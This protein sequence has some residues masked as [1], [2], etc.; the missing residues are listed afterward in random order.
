MQES[1][2]LGLPAAKLLDGFEGIMARVDGGE[3]KVARNPVKWILGNREVHGMRLILILIPLLLFAISPAAGGIFGFK[4][5]PNADM[6]CPGGEPMA[7]NLCFEWKILQCQ[8]CRSFTTDIRNRCELPKTMDC[9]DPTCD[10]NWFKWRE[11][12]APILPDWMKPIWHASEQALMLCY[13]SDQ[14]QDEC[15][16]AFYTNMKATCDM[17]GFAMPIMSAGTSLFKKAGKKTTKKIAEEAADETAEEF[18]DKALDAV[19]PD[20]C[21]TGAAA[22]MAIVRERTEHWYNAGQQWL[23]DHSVSSSPV[24]PTPYEPPLSDEEMKYLADVERDRNRNELYKRAEMA[25]SSSYRQIGDKYTLNFKSKNIKWAETLLSELSIKNGQ[26]ILV[27]INTSKDQDCDWY[28][29]A[30][31]ENPFVLSP[32][33]FR[34]GGWGHTWELTAIHHGESLVVFECEDQPWILVLNVTVEEKPSDS[35]DVDVS[36]DHPVPT[37]L[38]AAPAPTPA[39]PPP[40]PTSVLRQDNPAE[41]EN[42]TSKEGRSRVEVS[43]P[44]LGAPKTGTIGAGDQCQTLKDSRNDRSERVMVGM[45][46]TLSISLCAAD[47]LKC[48][49][50]DRAVIDDSSILQQRDHKFLKK[51]KLKMR[52][53]DYENWKFKALERGDAVIDLECV[54]TSGDSDKARTYRLVVDVGPMRR[55]DPPTPPPPPPGSE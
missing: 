18:V 14:T 37:V 7:V 15:V 47:W 12:M 22:S 3:G 5:C 35:D 16:D 53:A 23:A 38:A 28:D 30:V 50:T 13:A 49:W 34:E 40:A 31:I 32:S 55:Y 45:G 19:L 51:A 46:D 4:G 17:P 36:T 6:V 24:D 43:E 8:T 20:I 44:V 2:R 1:H 42:V 25:D 11:D 27:H 9:G 33:N 48:D 10:H 41:P 21:T 39:P 29:S 54:P 26:R 52:F